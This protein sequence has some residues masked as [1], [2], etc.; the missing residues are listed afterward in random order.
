ME[1]AEETG[2]CDFFF[3]FL[4]FL[5]VL[6]LLHRV[7]DLASLKS[8]W[9]R[10][11]LKGHSDGLEKPELRAPLAAANGALLKAQLHLFKCI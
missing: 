11:S 1:D 2:G 9:E 8:K 6:R 4:L 10:R 3:F 7:R 5:C